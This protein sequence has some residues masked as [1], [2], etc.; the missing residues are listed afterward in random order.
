MSIEVS[1]MGEMWLTVKE[2]IVQKDR[3]AAADHLV[4]VIADHA[5][6]ERELKSLGGTDKYLRHAVEEYLDEEVES[7]ADSEDDGYN[8]D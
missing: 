3:Q 8:D 2:Y 6:T 5:V 7:I 4:A 1:A